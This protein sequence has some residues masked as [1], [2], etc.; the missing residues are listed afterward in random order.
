MGLCSYDWL[1]QYKTVSSVNIP[2]LS[3]PYE[4]NF[5][6]DE[7]MLS[8]QGGIQLAGNG[9]VL[10]NFQGVALEAVEYCS[11]AILNEEADYVWPV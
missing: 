5:H 9:A 10:L 4:I 8:H 6:A 7:V 2:G 11:L 1:L 3:V